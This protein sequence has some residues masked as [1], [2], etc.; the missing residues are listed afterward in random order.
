M[1]P[2]RPL[3]PTDAARDLSR[4]VAAQRL[5]AYDAQAAALV[6]FLRA[7]A[8]RLGATPDADR[9]RREAHLLSLRLPPDLPLYPEPTPDG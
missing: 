4:Q 1:K 2:T 9:L 8:D 6:P 5:A 3:L 7:L